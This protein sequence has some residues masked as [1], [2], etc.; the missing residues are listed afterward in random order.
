MTN[1]TFDLKNGYVLIDGHIIAPLNLTDFLI[2]ASQNKIDVKDLERNEGWPIYG[3]DTKIN[4]EVF[5]MN[6]AY[7][8]NALYSLYASW[9]GGI[10]GKKNYDTTERELISDKNALSKIVEKVIGKTPTV[11]NYN[12]D[13][14]MF[15]WGNIAVAASLQS[16]M[17]T[18]GITWNEFERK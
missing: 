5:W 13:M 6:I 2:T 16:I 3:L 17:V 8:N 1:T 9:N 11:K 12:H 4:A 14:F 10:C 18:L 7:E 15:D